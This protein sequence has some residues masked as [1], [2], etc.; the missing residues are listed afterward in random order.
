ML[1]VNGFQKLARDS[2]LVLFIEAHERATAAANN[3]HLT[4]QNL[5][6]H[7]YWLWELEN[8]FRDLG[9][10][11]ECFTLPYWDV[12]NDAEAW[13][14]LD[15]SR[16][17]DDL[18]IYNSNL[19]AN[20]DIENDYCVGAPW[21]KE[22]YVTDSLCADDEE[23]MNCCLKRWHEVGSPAN[24]S[25]LW[26]KSDFAEVI[27]TD[28]KY[29]HFAEFTNRMF[30][31]HA[32]IHDFVGSI[33]NIHFNREQ[34]QPSADPLFPLFHMFIEIVRLLRE[35]CYQY[36]TVNMFDLEDY[37]PGSYEVINCSLDYAMDFSILCDETGGQPKRLCSDTTITP[38]L[39]YDISPN[40]EFQ[41]V[42]ELGEFWSENTKL[43]SMCAD[44]LNLSWWSVDGSLTAAPTMEPTNEPTMEPVMGM[45]AES[46]FVSDHILQSLGEWN[47]NIAMAP[48]LFLVLGVVMML[49]I[50][51]CGMTA[52]DK[53]VKEHSLYGATDSV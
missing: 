29:Q 32:S 15:P 24:D 40:T 51:H 5:F 33:A 50:K 37:M 22:Y 44:N 49:W 13:A 11:Y 47:S 53:M 19:G 1:Y 39:M 30:T 48:V 34:G 18:P 27:Y 6:W 52:M 8:T 14:Q 12:T 16:D 45:E 17:I 36:D 4:S 26:S 41:V 10:E 31:I 38:R 2:I 9:E 7:S 25:Q 43:R 42:Y 23:E 21:G 3:I 28:S 46:V 20:G 35:D